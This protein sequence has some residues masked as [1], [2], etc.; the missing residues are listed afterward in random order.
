MM[1]LTR[2][3]PQKFLPILP[4]IGSFCIAFLIGPPAFSETEIRFRPS[5]QWF[6]TATGLRVAPSAVNPDNEVLRIEDRSAGIDLRPSFKA[7]VDQFQFL[8]RPQLRHVVS[9]VKTL[10]KRTA[11]HP[12]STVKWIEAYGAWA[13]SESVQVSYGLQNYQWGAAETLNPSNRIFHE[14]ADSKGLLYAV[15]GRNLVRVNL[16][17]NKNLSSI[18]LAETE[19][20]KDTPVYQA[21]EVFQTKSLMKHEV[22]WNSGADYL[23]LVYGAA[24]TDGPWVGEYF[25][26]S[27]F[28]GLSV[29]ADASQQKSSH[30]WY[31][32]EEPSPL[33]GKTVIQM[34]QSKVDERKTYNLSV[35]GL[36]YSFEGGS[37]MRLE[38][39]LNSFG[40]STDECKLGLRVIDSRQTV[41]LPDIKANTARWLK[42]GLEFRGMSYGL[43]S[44]RLP[45]L[46]DW[47]DLTIYLRNLRSLQDRSASYYGSLEYGFGTASTA[48]LASLVTTGD[49]DAELRGFVS[50]SVLAGL[51]QDF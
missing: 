44:L 27:L 24:E 1:E 48:L 4:V 5:M 51:R 30:A 35:F 41:Q 29:Y 34:R 11:E 38:Y 43:V 40:W 8:A 2:Q 49:P 21:E 14:T 7:D 39:V 22:S 33:P 6:T 50:S 18:F 23:G 25:S 26:Q 16:T 19:P 47:K 36:R 46:F 13:A 3:K 32:T 12:K 31:P 15:Q 37:D 42:P 17:W 9:S 28:E 10:D 20:H 45:D